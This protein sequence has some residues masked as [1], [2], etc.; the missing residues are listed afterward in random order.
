MGFWNAA[1]KLAK[2]VAKDALDGARDMRAVHD[3]LETKGS[4][5]LKRI[6]ADNGLFSSATETEIRLARKVL[7]DR[8]E[9]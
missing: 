8:D 1:G 3:R 7:S 2:A 6:V 9:R 5:E 4:E